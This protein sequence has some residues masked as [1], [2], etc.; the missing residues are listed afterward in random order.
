MFNLREYQSEALAAVEASWNEG[1]NRPVIVLPTGAGKTVCFAGLIAREIEELRK[2]G[3]RVLV[4]AHREELLEQAESKIKAMVPGVWTA[5]VKGSRGQKTHDFA[6]V[7]VASVQTLARPK[8]REAIGKIGLVIVD[9]C[10]RYAAKSYK[11]VLAH[12]GCMDERQT[13]TVGFTATLTRMD[14]GLPEIWQSVAYQKKIHWMIKQG[15]LVPPSAR[16]IE[17]PGLNLASTR[18]TGGDLN[19]GD[20]AS[21]LDD[22]QAF[23]VIAGSWSQMAEDR[24]TIA[25]MPDVKTAQAMADAFHLTGV[26][27]EVVTGDTNS[28]ERKGIYE[29]F[30]N[31]QTRVLVN[32][33]VLTEGFDA[34]QTSC[35]VIGRPTINP[36]LYIQMVGRGLRLHPESGKT[37]CLVLDIAGASLK[38]NLAGV[39]DLESDCEGRCDCDCL[40]CGCSDRCKCGIQQCGC[41]CIEQH[42]AP[43]S[44]CS[45]AGSDDCGCGCPGD[46]DG[47]GLDGCVCALNPQGC[48]CRG[49][50]GPIAEDNE[51]EA[52]VLRKLV[53]VDIL[54]EELAASSY[55]WL[56]TDGGIDFLTIGQDKHLF[57]LPAPGAP[58]Q[59]YMGQVSGTGKAAVVSRLDK[60]AVDPATAR[61]GLEEV[62]DISGYSYNNRKAS[63]RRTPASEAQLGLLTRM[64]VPLSPGQTLKKG[65]ASDMLSA[66]K[67]SRTLDPRF[68]RYVSQPVQAE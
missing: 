4:L 57:L 46:M 47:T 5:I 45:C 2:K 56:K 11:E 38:H 33:M 20:L 40:S 6:D 10:H 36:G 49:G 60:G 37:D 9:E 23:S 52:D 21:A 62:A 1:I 24:P 27:A 42:E 43:S 32:C 18:V 64:G 54:G 66:A 55:T 41:R 31:G 15:Y 12:Y 51:V 14:G 63:W 22:S 26:T 34:P 17:V 8:R 3:Q 68:S 58:G 39:N 67:V 16:S 53:D 29:R 48:E 25:F 30:A 50:D 35:V 19:V 61:K 7:V 65:E 13:R 59:F 28:R 44:L